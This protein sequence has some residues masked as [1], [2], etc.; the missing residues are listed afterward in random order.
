M[1][2]F[3][4]RCRDVRLTQILCSRTSLP[5]PGKANPADK[6][7]KHHSEQHKPDSVTSKIVR[8]KVMRRDLTE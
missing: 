6:S 4:G 8:G 1:M 3:T 7:V 2:V 5:T